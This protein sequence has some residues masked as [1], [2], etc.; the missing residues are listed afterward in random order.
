MVRRDRVCCGKAG[1]VS[2]GQVWFG[3][4]RQVG[5]RPV[6]RGLLEYGAVRQVSRV[7]GW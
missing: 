7:Q 5:R 1:E 2:L 3:K 6:R 4:V